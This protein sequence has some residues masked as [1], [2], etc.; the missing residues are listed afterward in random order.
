MVWQ[1][2]KQNQS[3]AAKRAEK[4]VQGVY[5]EIIEPVFDLKKKILHEQLP[6]KKLMY[7]LKVK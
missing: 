2:L 5:E 6:S 7:N 1:F 4:I 3:R